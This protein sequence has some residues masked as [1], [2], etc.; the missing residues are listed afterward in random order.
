M[1]QG[2]VDVLLRHRG[3]KVPARIVA[4]DG[5]GYA[6]GEQIGSGGNAVVCECED[7]TDGSIYA[8]KF[9]LLPKDKGRLPRFEQET[10]IIQKLAQTN[11]DHLIR[12]I[13]HGEADG[14][15]PE[16]R[17]RRL[18]QVKVPFLIMERASKSLREHVA[19]A[20]DPIA[21]EIYFGQFRGLVSALSVLHEHALHRDIKPDNI[22][23]VGERWTISD[24]G[25]CLPTQ[26]EEGAQDLTAVGHIPGPR[27]WMSPEANNRSVGLPDEIGSASDVFQLAAVFWWVVTRR[28]PSG[29]LTQEDWTGSPRLYEPISKALQHSLGRRF[30]TAQDFGAAVTVAIEASD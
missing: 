21:P 5:R 26:P 8:V 19:E 2:W 13:A 17:S 30:Q 7:E 12:F 29:I 14:V 16:W 10:R 28:H 15:V 20:R 9:L 23:I 4:A 1:D 18:S 6:V 11:H 22:L 27:F 25:L 3:C 24:F